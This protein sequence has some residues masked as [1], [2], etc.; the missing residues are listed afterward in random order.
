VTA[1]KEPE[2]VVAS[3][4]PGW[5]RRGW[6]GLAALII[7]PLLIYA[8]VSIGG[9]W[10]QTRGLVADAEALQDEVIQARSENQR[11]QTAIALAR[12]DQAIESAAREELGLIKPGDTPVLLLAP[13]ATATAA[14]AGRAVTPT[15]YP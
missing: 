4:E 9:R 15:P 11:L 7:V 6:S 5:R 2:A 13:T 1:G 10:L 14:S 3:R 12:S 8:A